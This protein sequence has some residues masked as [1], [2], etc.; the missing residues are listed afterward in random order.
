MSNSAS[1]VTWGRILRDRHVHATLGHC[2]R[3]MACA[4]VTYYTATLV[5]VMYCDI[6]TQTSRMLERQAAS[7]MW[8]GVMYRVGDAMLGYPA[9]SNVADAVL[10]LMQPALAIMM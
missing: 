6:T 3:I 4:I 5:L 2:M 1:T 7:H 8:S 10:Q 9:A